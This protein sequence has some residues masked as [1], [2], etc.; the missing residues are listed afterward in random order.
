M[1]SIT[2]PILLDSTGKDINETLNG[3][4]HVLKAAHTL[5]DDNVTSDKYVWSSKKIVEALTVNA[6]VEGTNSVS[7]DAIAAT[8]LEVVTTITTAPTQV[9]M[10][11]TGEDDLVKQ[12][13]Y[14]VPV[15]GTYYWNTGH[16]IMEDGTVTKL[17]AHY[18]VPSQGRNTLTATNVDT[19]KVTYKTISKTSGG[20]M[21][22]FKVINGGS[23]KEEA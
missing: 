21:D 19:L 17:A 18:L 6:I 23:A 12:I 16:F 5:I 22:D 3:I 14:V 13:S 15:N 1:S 20:N 2:S 8:P 9:D 7:F 4:Q 10:V 11:L